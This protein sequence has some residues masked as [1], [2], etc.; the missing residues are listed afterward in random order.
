MKL[1]IYFTDKAPL[2]I[3]D[4]ER[5]RLSTPRVTF[6]LRAASLGDDLQQGGLE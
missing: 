3:E 2:V 5:L 6:E 1:V 4:A